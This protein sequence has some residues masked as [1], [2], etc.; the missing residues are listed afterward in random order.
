MDIRG[1]RDFDS[2][3]SEEGRPDAPDPYPS[4]PSI[5]DDGEIIDQPT[6]GEE[7][8]SLLDLPD[9][10]PRRVSPGQDAHEYVRAGAAHG[11]LRDLV[12]APDEPESPDALAGR[13]DGP[14]DFRTDTVAPEAIRKSVKK[15]LRES[16]S[17]TGEWMI[18]TGLVL[19]AHCICPAAGHL[20]TLAFEAKEI[21]DDAVALANP[22]GPGELHVPLVHLAPGIEIEAG[23]QLGDEDQTDGPCLSVFAVPGDGGLFGGWALE[24]DTDHEA[25]GQEVTKTE[26]GTTE[27]TDVFLVDLSQ[28]VAASPDRRKRA[29][30]LRGTACRLQSELW[31]MPEYDGTSL[32]VL[33]DGQTDLGMWLRRSVEARALVDTAGQ[34]SR[35]SGSGPEPEPPPGRESP[36]HFGNIFPPALQQG[37]Q[38][39]DEEED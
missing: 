39:E 26:Q 25:A 10:L 19:T 14:G 33:Y 24:R 30:I 32:M 17:A 7:Y 12:A 38:G 8:A 37:N 20:V 35:I 34:G 31:A 15:S 28:A 27:G 22:D 29:A 18:E 36:D 4:S 9:P 3:E 16:I 6:L 13:P 2:S 23:L 11:D 1:F 5:P 21:F